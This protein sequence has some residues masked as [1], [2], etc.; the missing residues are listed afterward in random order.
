MRTIEA[1]DGVTIRVRTI[2]EGSPVLL[3]PSLGRGVDDYDEVADLLA[4]RGF[5]SILPDPRGIGGSSGPAPRDLFDLA[6]DAAAVI[7]QLCSGPVG[8]VGHAFGNRVARA[9]AALAPE[10]VERV[11]LL[12]GG[13]QAVMSDT[14]RAALMGSV[15][16]DS[17]PDADRLEDLETAFF[18]PGNDPAVWLRGWYP[19]V[20]EQQLAANER[21]ETARWW[22]AGRAHVLLVQAESDPVAPPGNA[23][24]LAADIDDRLTLVRLRRASHAIL[25]EQPRAVAALVAGYLSGESDGAVLQDTADRLIA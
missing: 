4:D 22:T 3:I 23:E 10:K 20:A 16:Q 18:F 24:A 7:D 1:G 17:K 9:L 12:A 14:V 15:A 19:A 8:V 25:P 6:R 21:T 11:V 5:K 13:G 2:G